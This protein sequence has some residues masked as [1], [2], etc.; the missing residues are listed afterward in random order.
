MNLMIKIIMLIDTPNVKKITKII[1][2]MD[3]YLK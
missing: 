2:G 3:R 1:I